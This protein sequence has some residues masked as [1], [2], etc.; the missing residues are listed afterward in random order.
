[1]IEKAGFT[2]ESQ[3]RNSLIKYGEVLD[4]FLYARIRACAVHNG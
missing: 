2:L 4:Q 3:L 1:M